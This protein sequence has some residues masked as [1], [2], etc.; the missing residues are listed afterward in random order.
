MHP[1]NITCPDCDRPYLGQGDRCRSCAAR[2]RQEQR[3][4]P[5]LTVG[6]NPA[7]LCMCGC[8]Q[9]APV[10]TSTRKRS[11]TVEGQSIRYIRGHASRKFPPIA[12]EI[13]LD[14][15]CWNW[16]GVVQGER[17]YGLFSQNGKQ[18]RAYR[19]FY[20]QR[21]GPIPHGLVIDHLCRNPMCVNPDHLQAVTNAE[22]IRRGIAAKLMAD[23]VREMRECYAA[24]MMIRDI[25][26]RFGMSMSQTSRIVRR[27]AWCDVQ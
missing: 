7:G 15:G 6:P 23:E 13:D 27:L 21:H 26:E 1:Q 25:A 24:G 12:Y 3:Y 20:E 2:L 8:G 4:G 16:M 19:W 5:P 10:A 9:P 14:S 22:N 11:G 17:G 18:L